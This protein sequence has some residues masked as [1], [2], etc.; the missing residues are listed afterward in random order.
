LAFREMDMSTIPSSSPLSARAGNWIR[1]AFAAASVQTEMGP[2]LPA[3]FMNAGFPNPQ[4]IA[5]QHVG[6]ASESPVFAIMAGTIRSLM[7]LIERAKIA[8]GAEIDVETLID[9]SRDE[10]VEDADHHVFAAH[11]RR[12]GQK[13][14]ECYGPGA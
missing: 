10:A 11:S 8:T 6:S 12:L 14:L 3:I 1:N 13:G 9:R 5:G 4:M 7:P 2:K